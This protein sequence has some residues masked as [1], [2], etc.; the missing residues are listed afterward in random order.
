MRIACWTSKSTNAQAEYVILTDFPL[1]QQFHERASKL[2]YVHI[3]LLFDYCFYI[4]IIKHK[5]ENHRTVTAKLVA[6]NK[7]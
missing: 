3:A 2:R 7:V 1:K 5:M 4:L 6:Q